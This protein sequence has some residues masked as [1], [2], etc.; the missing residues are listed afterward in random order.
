[1]RIAL[2]VV[3]EPRYHAETTQRLRELIVQPLQLAG[4]AVD[5]ILLLWNSRLPAGQLANRGNHVA[6][7]DAS[8]RIR[9]PEE[10]QIISR[11]LR[12]KF[13]A[14]L[15]KPSFSAEAYIPHTKPGTNCWGM[16]CQHYSWN[17]AA[18]Q[19]PICEELYGYHYDAI[20]RLRLDANFHHEISLPTS[21]D[22]IYVPAVEGHMK[23]PFNPAQMCNDQ[24]AIGPRTLMLQF[25]R[26]LQHYPNFIRDKLLL[27]PESVVHHYLRH[28]MRC[29]FKTF[30]L[31]YNLQR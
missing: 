7:D 3:G 31:A 17:L 29:D 26:L 6:T 4:H 9:K 16:M 21:L 13:A 25:L 5:V 10:H 24:I 8:A 2:V 27:T 14:F 19:I 28:I 15:D 20:M 22:T 1:M 12:P 23:K 30:P 18:Q 11:M